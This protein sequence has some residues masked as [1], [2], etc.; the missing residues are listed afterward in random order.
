MATAAP[1]P[2]S[3]VSATTPTSPNSDD[4]LFEGAGG[5]IDTVIATSSF[6]LGADSEILKAGS[7]V[8]SVSLVGN[9][10]AN[11]ITG[12]DAGGVLDGAGGADTLAGGFGND[13]YIVDPLDTVMEAAGGGIDTIVAGFSYTLGAELENLTA[14]AGAGGIALTGNGLANVVTGNDAA[15]VLDGKGGADTLAGHGGNDTYFVDNAADV[16]VEGPGGGTDTVIAS[17]SYVLTAAARSSHEVRRSEGQSGAHRQRLRQRHYRQCRHKHAEGRRRQRLL[18]GR[19]RQDTLDRRRR[20]GFFVFDTKPDKA[21][22]VDIA[23]GLLGQGR[24]D[25]ARQRV[26][27]KSEGRVGE[28]RASSRRTPSSSARRRTDGK[29][30]SS[31]TRSGAL[32]YDAD[33]TGGAPR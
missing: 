5:G 16:I 27:A 26:F 22:N 12:G 4:T 13:T 20:P 33:G 21:A 6:T 32:Y 25:L 17:V 7:S 3:A 19:R 11:E 10:L 8:G 30:A 29:T 18:Q 2:C 1:T 24:H 15:N 31:T 28:E 23:D 9:G 14:A